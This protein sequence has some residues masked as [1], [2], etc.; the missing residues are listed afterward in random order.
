VITKKELRH[1]RDDPEKEC[2]IRD[3]PEKE[4]RHIRDDPEK[5]L[6]HIRDVIPFRGAKYNLKIETPYGVT[7]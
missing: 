1:V 6:R 2:H 4:L 3:D 7:H 5:E